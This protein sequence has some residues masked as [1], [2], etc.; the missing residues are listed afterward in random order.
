M[1]CFFFIVVASFLSVFN[2]KGDGSEEDLISTYLWE[3]ALRC[4]HQV[5]LVVQEG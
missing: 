4:A 5:L 1:L 2:I 3:A